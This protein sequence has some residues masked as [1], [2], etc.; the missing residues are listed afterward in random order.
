[1]KDSDSLAP[2]P[3][4]S[5]RSRDI[6]VTVIPRCPPLLRVSHQELLSPHL[7]PENAGEGGGERLAERPMKIQRPTLLPQ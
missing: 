7:S 5:V 6:P 4:D 3:S 1:M 2:I